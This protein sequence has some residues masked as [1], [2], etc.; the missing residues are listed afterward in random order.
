MLGQS[1]SSGIS[2]TTSL[3][4]QQLGLLQTCRPPSA[5]VATKYLYIS[6]KEGS[7]YPKSDSCMM[8][9]FLCAYLYYKMPSQ[10]ITSKFRRMQLELRAKQ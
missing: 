7:L 8:T 10:I 4:L 9:E 6:A 3:C 2:C 1:L 5:A